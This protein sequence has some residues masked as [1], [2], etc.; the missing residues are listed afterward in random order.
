MKLYLVFKSIPLTLPVYPTKPTLNSSLDDGC[1]SIK[2]T[3]IYI[4]KNNI[5]N[6]FQFKLDDHIIP[7]I[8]ILII[9]RAKNF[10]TS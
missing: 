1:R 4:L 6:L 7:L 5:Q 3:K 8:K 2:K 9:W 10:L